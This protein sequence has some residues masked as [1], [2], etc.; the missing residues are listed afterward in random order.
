MCL[1]WTVNLFWGTEQTSWVVAT[2]FGLPSSA[3]AGKVSASVSPQHRTISLS[4]GGN[5]TDTGACS[6]DFD[7][8]LCDL[9]LGIAAGP[10]ALE[11]RPVAA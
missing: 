10:L 3:P 8:S 1:R 9:L 2:A 4:T 11:D 7:G 6:A 5:L